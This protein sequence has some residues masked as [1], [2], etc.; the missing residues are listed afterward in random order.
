MADTAWNPDTY[1]RFATLRSKPFWDL[2]DLID[3]TGPSSTMVDLGCGSGELT[4]ELADRLDVASAIG[5]DSSTAMLERAHAHDSTRC[6]F[7]HDDIATWTSAPPVDLL[8]ANASLQWVPDHPAVLARWMSSVAIGGQIAV[9]VPA[10]ADHPSHTCSASVARREPFVSAMGG[11]APPDPVAD[12]V[13]TPEE[14]S[15]LLHALGVDEPIV[16]LHV[17]PQL[18]DSSSQVVEWTRGTS[19]TRFFR[20]LPRELHDRFVEA[21][22]TELLGAI[23]DQSPYFYTFKRILLAGTR[24]R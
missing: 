7:I 20:V 8:V 12:N 6:S 5:V 24:T 9:Q 19:L 16:Q 2:V 4:A 22:R 1:S 15:E 23:G 17:Y 10:N 3:P 21:Y 13:L 18:M 11:S 14:Y